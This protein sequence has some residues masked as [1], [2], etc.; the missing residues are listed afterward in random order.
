M[1]R[2]PDKENPFKRRNVERVLARDEVLFFFLLSVEE[3]GEEEKKKLPSNDV[4][5]I[6]IRAADSSRSSKKF[7]FSQS[8]L[9]ER[10]RKPDSFPIFLF[11][12]I[13]RRRN[14][15]S[16]GLSLFKRRGCGE[17]GKGV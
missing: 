5:N 3:G 2:S 12:M 16:D 1:N 7:H 6:L 14:T 10:F 11:L 8:H 4:Y 15:I 17:D 9:S 13:L